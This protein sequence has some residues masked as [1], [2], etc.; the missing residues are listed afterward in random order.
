MLT[1]ELRFVLSPHPPFHHHL[2]SFPCR[3]ANAPVNAQGGKEFNDSHIPAGDTP[4][5]PL[6]KASVT[7]DHASHYESAEQEKARLQQQY[8][9]AAAGAGTGTTAS[10]AAEASAGATLPARVEAVYDFDGQE[11]GDLSFKIGAVIEV[12]GKEDDMWWH[13]TVAGR[14]GIFPSNYTRAL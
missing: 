9:N 14:S 12:T 11:E 5:D 3:F 13:G 7:P 1:D 8:N 2:P 6:A 4:P 10:S